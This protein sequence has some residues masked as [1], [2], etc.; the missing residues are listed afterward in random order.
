MQ[1]F[2]EFFFE[3]RQKKTAESKQK[4]RQVLTFKICY[5]MVLN[6]LATP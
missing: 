5:N 3:K 2:F 6:Q 1:L 4:L